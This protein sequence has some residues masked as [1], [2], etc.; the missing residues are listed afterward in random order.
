MRYLSVCGELRDYLAR[1]LS[2]LKS[3]QSRTSGD[4]L[5]RLGLFYSA[6]ALCAETRYFE[7]EAR[8][9]CFRRKQELRKG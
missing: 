4:E 2:V 8:G 9:W 1:R 7:S 6:M 3:D 5:V